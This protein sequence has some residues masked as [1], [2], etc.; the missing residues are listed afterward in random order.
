M[1]DKGAAVTTFGTIGQY[2]GSN[3]PGKPRRYLLNTGGRLKLFEI[4]ADVVANDYRAFE[5]SK[6]RSG[7]G[8]T[9]AIGVSGEPTIPGSRSGGAVS[10]NRLRSCSRSHVGELVQVPHLAER[11]AELEQAEVVDRQQRALA[12]D[13]RATAEHRLDRVVVGDQRGDLRVGDPLEQRLVARVEC[14][15]TC[16]GSP[17]GRVPCS[18]RG[19]WW[20]SRCGAGACR[21]ARR[22]RCRPP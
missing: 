2:V 13:L 3:I 8:Q 22:P 5:M 4:R 16:G 10:R 18:T 9:V 19:P 1:V 11:D 14:R 20:R 7:E 17:P 6:A 21:R 12:V 15:C